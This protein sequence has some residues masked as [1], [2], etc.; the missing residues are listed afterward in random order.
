MAVL[1]RFFLLAI[2]LLVV[3]GLIIAFTLGRSCLWGDPEAAIAEEIRDILPP[4]TFQTLSSCKP[5]S[6]MKQ[7]HGQPTTER[8]V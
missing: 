5:I 1:G 8:W 7:A 6:T 2:A 3:S 4:S